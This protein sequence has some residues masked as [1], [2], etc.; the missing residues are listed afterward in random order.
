MSKETKSDG[1]RTV[2]ADLAALRER[3]QKTSVRIASDK[4]RTQRFK[5]GKVHLYRPQCRSLTFG[6]VPS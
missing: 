5:G 4:T 6:L 2:A 1:H 3:P